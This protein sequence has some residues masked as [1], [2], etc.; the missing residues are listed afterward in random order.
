MSSEHQ[1]SNLHFHRLQ[2]VSTVEAIQLR[3]RTPVEQLTSMFLSLILRLACLSF[4]TYLAFN[5]LR[6]Q[7]PL[8]PDIKNESSDSIV[9]W[10]LIAVSFWLLLQA[11]A[12]RKTPAQRILSK[13]PKVVI[14]PLTILG[15]LLLARKIVPD[16][17]FTAIAMI[18][19]HWN[20]SFTKLADSEPLWVTTKEF[21]RLIFQPVSRLFV[22]NKIT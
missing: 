2:V 9:F 20:I 4:A 7:A 17:G 21:F 22:H 3:G 6:P 16:S 12:D 8:I 1:D 14:A 18:V 10:I 11:F 19:W 15:L 5:Y 13:S